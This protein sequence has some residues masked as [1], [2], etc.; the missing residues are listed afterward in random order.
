MLD[1]HIQRDLVYRL[2][3]SEGLRFSELKPDEIENKLFTYH[4]KKAMA[5]GFVEK[6][7]EG[8]YRLTPEGR[9][10]GVGAFRSHHMSIDRAYSIL[11]LVV[12]RKSDGAWLLT[13]RQTHPLFGRSGFMHVAPHAN[14]EAPERARQECKDK[15]GLDGEFTV[16]GSGFFRYYDGD[17]LESF[18]HFTLL[19]CDDVRGELSQNNELAEYFWDTEPDFEAEGMLPNMPMLKDMYQSQRLQFVEK[20]YHI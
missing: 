2:A 12:R 17:E 20:T 4:L 13:R 3:F 14:A 1:H 10:V 6:D 19:K 11:L 16:C 15:T 9:R 7:E 18:T 8:L 5:A